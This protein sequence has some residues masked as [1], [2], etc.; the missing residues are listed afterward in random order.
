M[1]SDRKGSLSLHFNDS[2]DG[3]MV[4]VVI[5]PGTNLVMSLTDAQGGV[6]DDV[7]LRRWYAQFPSE[8]LVR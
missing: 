4:A 3:I 7:Y 1:W 2:G 5:E 8:R 6:Y